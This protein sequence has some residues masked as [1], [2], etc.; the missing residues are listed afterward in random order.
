[1]HPSQGGTRGG[2]KGGP[3]DGFTIQAGGAL[4]LFMDRGTIA[5]W[6]NGTLR[7]IVPEIPD[8]RASRFN[9]VIADPHGRVFCG[10]M[11]TDERK[12]RLYR[13]HLDGSLQ[14]LPGKEEEGQFAGGLFRLGW[15]STGTARILLSDWLNGGW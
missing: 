5:L 11:S 4:L 1:M 7:E 13:L 14:L 2:I 10:T 3:F 15:A 8:E 9:D 12:G 6:K